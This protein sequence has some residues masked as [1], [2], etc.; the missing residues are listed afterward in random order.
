MK[1]AAGG[2]RA[3]MRGWA[4]THRDT[5]IDRVQTARGV[6]LAQRRLGTD[7]AVRS[8]QFAVYRA[9]RSLMFW[10]D[11]YRRLS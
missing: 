10:D 2:L 5:A 11:L 6:V 9:E 1:P 8:A 3:A 4:L 7:A